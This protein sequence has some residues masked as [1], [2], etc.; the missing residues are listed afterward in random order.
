MGASATSTCSYWVSWYKVF[1]TSTETLMTVVIWLQDSLSLLLA[2]TPL[3]VYRLLV[4]CERP[5]AEG[6]RN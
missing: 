6:C 2:A 1:S 5:L 4:F 3:L